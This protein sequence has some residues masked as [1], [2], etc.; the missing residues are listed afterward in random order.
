[1]KCQRCKSERNTYI[2]AKC[3]DMCNVMQY[4]DSGYVEHNGY[5]PEDIG[6]G[7]G[8]YVEF[9]YCLDCGQIHGKFPLPLT[10]IEKSDEQ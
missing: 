1:M 10:E 8:D 9:V 3:S 4:K 2:T 5:V 6:I 7:G